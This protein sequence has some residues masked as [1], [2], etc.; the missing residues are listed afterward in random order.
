MSPMLPSL[1]LESI[2][3]GRY[4]FRALNSYLRFA[5]LFLTGTFVVSLLVWGAQPWYAAEIRL[6]KRAPNSKPSI[7]SNLRLQ[8][9][10]PDKGNRVDHYVIQPGETLSSIAEKLSVDLSS[11]LELN[12]RI[13]DPDFIPAGMTLRVPAQETMH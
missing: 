8:I 5:L 9:I 3:G 1:D 2:F 4:F 7:T 11:L 13:Q 6:Y 12:A 10:R